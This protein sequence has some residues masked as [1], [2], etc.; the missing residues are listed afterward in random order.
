MQSILLK[1]SELCELFD[2]IGTTVA[3]SVTLC[4]TVDSQWVRL[5]P[6]R[7][8]PTGEEGEHIVTVMDHAGHST[9][10]GHTSVVITVP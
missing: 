1:C 9:G 4:L 10:M 7:L 3:H 2:D 8:G 5:G 6:T